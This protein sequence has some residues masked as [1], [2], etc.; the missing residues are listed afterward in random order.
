MKWTPI[1]QRKAE[2]HL[3][4]LE[5]FSGKVSMVFATSASV[6]RYASEALAAKTIN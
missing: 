2:T 3:L 5:I 6:G 1:T 4:T